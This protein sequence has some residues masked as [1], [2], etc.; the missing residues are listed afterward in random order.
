MM[1]GDRANGRSM[2]ALSSALPRNSRRTMTRAVM[3]PNTVLMG[4]TM[5]VMVSVSQ[6]ACWNPG[7]EMAL[8]TGSRPCSKVL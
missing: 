3:T 6:K 4:T 1:M 7:R 5:A 8:S 2:S